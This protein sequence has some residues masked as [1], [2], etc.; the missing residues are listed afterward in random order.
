MT[1]AP[2][3]LL[4]L[5]RWTLHR[6]SRDPR[7]P[8]PT[9]REC[10]M[11]P[12]PVRV[13]PSKN[14]THSQPYRHHCLPPAP[15]TFPST[16]SDPVRENRIHPVK[17]ALE[18]LLRVWDQIP[19]P[20]CRE[21][22]EIFFFHGLLFP[23]PRFQPSAVMRSQP[24]LRGRTAHRHRPK[25]SSAS[26]LRWIPSLVHTLCSELPR[27]SRNVCPASAERWSTNRSRGVIA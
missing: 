27:G 14:S 12:F 21:G 3:N 16:A 11:S 4:T 8:E 1:R 7:D 20:R 25:A 19:I 17:R 10:A 22:A 23:P 24:S 5:D 18:A 2:K 13:H 26:A 6:R 15:S 9:H